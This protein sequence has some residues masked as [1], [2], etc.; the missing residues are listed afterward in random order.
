MLGFLGDEPR[1][2]AETLNGGAVVRGPFRDVVEA[3][4]DNSAPSSGPSE[5][6]LRT[7]S[8]SQRALN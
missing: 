3:V 8:I 7:P 2:D 4:V 1:P 5:P 6:S